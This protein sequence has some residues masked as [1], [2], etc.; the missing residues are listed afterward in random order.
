MGFL[1]FIVCIILGWKLLKWWLIR[2]MQNN[3]RQMY[4]QMFGG[5]PMSDGPDPSHQTRHSDNRRAAGW[6]RAPHKKIF[7]SSTGEYVKYEE[8]S[9]E[10]DSS[11]KSGDTS[12]HTTTQVEQQIV[13]VEW[14]D[15]K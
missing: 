11:S 6:H 2:K 12:T 14:E 5:S 8:I 7:D 13:D 15:I 10:A 3:A 1:I 4:E 9:V